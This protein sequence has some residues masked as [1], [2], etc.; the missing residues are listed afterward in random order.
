MKIGVYSCS[1]NEEQFAHRWAES[2]RDADQLLVLDTGSTDATVEVLRDVS[3]NVGFISIKPWRFDDAKNAALHFLRP[4]IDIAVQLDLDEV[5][6]PGWRQRLEEVW[7][8]ETT[9]LKYR[10]VWSWTPDGRPDRMFYA[11]KIGGRHTHRWRNPV[12]E[13]LAATVPEVVGVC[14]TVL[15]EHYPDNNKSR[16]SYLPLL[17]LSVQE[18]LLDDRSSHYLGREYYFHELYPQAIEEFKRHIKLP[19]AVWAT[20]RA[21]SLR[22]GAK[23]YEAMGNFIAANNW[24]VL[25]VLEDGQSREALV[26]LAGYLMRQ[27]EWTGAVHYAYKALQ[28]PPDQSSYISERYATEEGPYD[29]AAVANFYMGDKQQALNCIMKALEFNPKDVRLQENLRWIRGDEISAA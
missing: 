26:D 2:A 22:Y 7:K 19:T 3:V 10:Y 25:A 15:I 23:C 6:T 20:E 1:L 5:L 8:P 17:Q 12:H 28:I 27:K 21:A 11:D 29:I 18:N 24:Y 16:A 13:V 9:R 4:D 14:D